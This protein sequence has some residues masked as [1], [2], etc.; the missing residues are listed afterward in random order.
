MKTAFIIA[1]YLEIL[2][3]DVEKESVLQKL[4]K[5]NNKKIFYLNQKG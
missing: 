4:Q 3:F 1:D 5:T 2:G